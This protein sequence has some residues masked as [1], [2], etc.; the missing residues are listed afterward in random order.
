MFDQR[1]TNDFEDIGE[2]E[3]KWDENG[4]TLQKRQCIEKKRKGLSNW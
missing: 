4:I 1:E 2:R 3:Y